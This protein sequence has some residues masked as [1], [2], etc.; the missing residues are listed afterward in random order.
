M[1]DLVT[2]AQ[3]IASGTWAVGE[4]VALL[5]R[6]REQL[7][8]CDLLLVRREDAQDA[9]QQAQSAAS[10]YERGHE[11]KSYEREA[12]QLL[13][14]D[15]GA[16]GAGMKNGDSVATQVESSALKDRLELM[17]DVVVKRTDDTILTEAI[18]GLHKGQFI[19]WRHDGSV[20][21]V[22]SREFAEHGVSLSSPNPRQG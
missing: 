15:A 8:S 11:Y 17:I 18:D 1:S 5:H 3:I 19:L 7:L 4:R 20:I 2:R 6:L 22:G 10:A 14:L 13:G 16:G 21:R 12:R 9:L